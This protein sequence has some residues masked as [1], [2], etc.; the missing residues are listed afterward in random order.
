[1]FSTYAN[2]NTEQCEQQHVFLFQCVH[3]IHATI[4][5]TASTGTYLL[6]ATAAKASLGARSGA[7]TSTRATLYRVSARAAVS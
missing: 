4:L 2:A 5:P 6:R 1:M 3:Q 7:M